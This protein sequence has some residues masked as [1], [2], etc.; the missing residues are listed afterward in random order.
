MER[1]TLTDAQW[2]TI[3]PVLLAHPRL[4]VGA[5]ET[6]R[7]FLD[8][9]LWILRSGAQWRFL[10]PSVGRWNS[11]FKRFS[12]WCKQGVWTALREAVGSDRDLQHLLID[13]TIVRAHPCAAGA[14]GSRAENEALGRSRGGFS[15]KIHTVTDALGNPLDFVL[16]GGQVA[17]VTQAE[18][19]L[20]NHSTEA[21]IGD[22]GYDADSVVEGLAARGIEAVI[23]PRSNRRTP[24]AVDWHLYKERHLIECFFSKLKQYRRVFSRFEKTA[25]NFMGF[26]QFAAVLIWTR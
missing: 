5:H 10:P 16:T 13:S 6:C 7:R 11:V 15:T 1:A 22:K 20:A 21:V 14:A 26:L 23:P 8:A 25:R 3:L 12:R 4:Y 17:D 19:L 18:A 9:V 24:R 2:T